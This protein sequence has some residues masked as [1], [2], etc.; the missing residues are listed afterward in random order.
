VAANLAALGRP[1]F[2]ILNVGTG[3]ETDVNTL[4]QKLA[5]LCRVT[6]PARHEAQKPGEQR[7]SCIDA[8]RLERELG[9]R[10]GVGIDEGLARTAEWF[11][12]RAAG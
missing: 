11:R 9:V 12:A 3:A 4:Y 8:A 7:R 5:E 6:R 2:H 10:V 1:G